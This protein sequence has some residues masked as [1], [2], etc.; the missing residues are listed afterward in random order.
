MTQLAVWLDVS[1]IIEYKVHSD[2]N[3]L[4]YMYYVRELCMV[5]D[6]LENLIKIISG[7]GYKILL[8]H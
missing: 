7:N 2:I 1:M 4:P 8:L 5:S 3:N 6:V